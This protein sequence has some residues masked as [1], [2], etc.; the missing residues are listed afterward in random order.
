MSHRDFDAA[1]AERLRAIDPVEFT[2]GGERFSCVLEPA[3]G[4]ALVLAAA[5]EPEQNEAAAVKAILNFT[6]AL[7]V[8]EHRRRWRRMIRR[9][10][11]NRFRRSPRHPIAASEVIELGT[12]LA[13]AYTARPFSPSSGSSA[14]RPG[15][16]ARSN[17]TSSAAGAATSAGSE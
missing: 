4:D 15:S 10:V 3:L 16:G 6:A 5:P 13:M 7:I 12:W 8:P 17:G 9:Q 1:R 14:G 2:L 11:P